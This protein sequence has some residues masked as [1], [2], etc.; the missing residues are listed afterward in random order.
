MVIIGIS[1]FSEVDMAYKA[2]II[3]VAIDC[4]QGPCPT[5]PL[6]VLSAHQ[7]QDTVTCWYFMQHF[8][9]NMQTLSTSSYQSIY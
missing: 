7:R 3:C 4:L 2:R 6:I 9:L 1:W 5:P 8:I